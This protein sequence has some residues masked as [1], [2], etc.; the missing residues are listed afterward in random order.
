MNE[1]S[2]TPAIRTLLFVGILMLSLGVRLA[3]L[4]AAPLS[5][6]E[7]HE[8]L[9]AAS[10]TSESSPFWVPAERGPSA[11]GA[12]QA[13][14]WLLF[15]VVGSTNATARF[16]PALLGALVVLAPWMLR[17]RLGDAPALAAS[18][19]LALSPVLVASSQLAGGAGIALTA[20]S[21]A[22]SLGILAL[23]G[24]LPRE[25]A[26]VGIGGALALG[27]AAGPPFFAG[28]LG[29][30]IA[31]VLAAATAPSAWPT[32]RGQETARMILP[33]A[34]LIGFLGAAVVSTAA[35]L[36]PGGWSALGEGLRQWLIGWIGPGSM[37]ALTPLAILV[38]YEPLTLVFGIVGIVSARRERD[39]LGIGLSLW[40]GF[41]LLLAVIYPDREGASLAWS[42]V[43]LALLAGRAL[44]AEGE[45]LLGQRTPWAAGGVAALLIILVLYSGV[46]LSAYAGGVGPGVNPLNVGLRLWIA[47]G[48]LFVFG[49]TAVLIGFG[50]S[51]AVAR[52]GAF[53]AAALSLFMMT[54]STGTS[55]S[56]RSEP[57]GA[58]ELWAPTAPSHGLHRL[59]STLASFSSSQTGVRG[60]LPLA[61]V[62]A[63]PPP[64]LLW[65]SRRLP[66]F[67][68]SDSGSP[69]SPP[70]I[71]LPLDAPAPESGEAYLGQ[72]IP[73]AERW[74]FSGPFPDDPI[75]WWFRR[76]LPI[77]ET[78]WVLLVRSDVATLGESD[79]LAGEGS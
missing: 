68:T 32:G 44:V 73:V 15:Q 40:A 52:S 18:F 33:G 31:A 4:G 21:L 5:D 46:Q 23:D 78:T 75:Q 38:A 47:L 10:G 57:L 74:D 37:H 43:P 20:L 30:L 35:G 26:V 70:L 17:R 76:S 69:E 19:L 53:L 9:N 36:H 7:A 8:A 34:L 49:L 77:I 79:L 11:G 24:D 64:S 65:A 51:W 50:W 45:F 59:E 67:E 29:L 56:G 48:A 55:L 41:A 2:R 72:T 63:D 6:A 1:T 42:V 71:L 27:I 3:G 66:R 16:V 14:T 39:V 54:I 28:L 58:Q 61:I 62:A 25:R 13:A 60:E 22:A 12:Y